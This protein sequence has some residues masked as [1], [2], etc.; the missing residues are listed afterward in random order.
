MVGAQGIEPWTSRVWSERRTLGGFSLPYD[1]VNK[2]EGGGGNQMNRPPR[3]HAVRFR[4]LDHDFAR[5]LTLNGSAE[6][7]ERFALLVGPP[8]LTGGVS[9][10]SHRPNR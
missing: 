5:F 10:A 1:C 9:G 4:T 3:Y 2:Q 6:I 8:F 7:R